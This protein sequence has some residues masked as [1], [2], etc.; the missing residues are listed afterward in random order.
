M[1]A[2]AL[3]LAALVAGVVIADADIPALAKKY[4]G[5]SGSDIANAVLTASLRAARLDEGIVRHLYFEEAVE[6]M[7]NSKADNSDLG[8]LVS[9]RT[10]SEEYVR[11]QFEGELP[12]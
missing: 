3:I 2:I 12:K 7:L 11:S 6:R 1:I 9:R 10:V 8:K 5:V 4:D